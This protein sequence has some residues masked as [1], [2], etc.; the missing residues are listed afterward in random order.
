MDDTKSR[1][2]TAAMR[3][4]RR[5]GLEGVR[6]QNVSRLAE[7]SP[8]ALYRYFHS[9]EQLLAECFTCVDKQ[10]AAIF[11]RL[12]F[13]P[14]AVLSDP[15]GAVRSLWAPYFRFWT[16]HPDETVFYYRFRDSAAFPQ[17]YRTR[18]T[19]YF[20]EFANMVHLFME[21]FPSLRQI[22]QDVLWLHVL[23]CTLLYAKWVV[24]GLLPNTRETEDTVFQFLTV[25]LG[26]YLRP[27][28]PEPAQTKRQHRAEGFPP[29]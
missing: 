15:L 17:F 13:D 19:S 25:G 7:V 1:I 14:R 8:G 9:K 18:D 16:S 4:V 3:A 6:I 5:Y 26:G 12:V 22:N 21:A 20:Q 10:A 2:I 29:L 24:E 11:D 23:T 28:A 27:G